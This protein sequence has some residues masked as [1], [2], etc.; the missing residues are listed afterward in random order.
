MSFLCFLPQ[1]VQEGKARIELNRLELEH[2]MVRAR[3]PAMTRVLNC[4]RRRASQL[5]EKDRGLEKQMF[6][7][8]HQI[9]VF[10][11]GF[12][13]VC[14]SNPLT[15]V[16]HLQTLRSEIEEQKRNMHSQYQRLVESKVQSTQF[17]S[18]VLVSDGFG[19]ADGRAASNGHGARRCRT[20][21]QM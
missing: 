7:K 18:L 10:S 9:Q 1:G 16:S 2:K 4:D 17:I 19:S 11:G 21:V 13:S 3:S 8:D 5:Q 15:P 6:E 14:E 12:L 20:R